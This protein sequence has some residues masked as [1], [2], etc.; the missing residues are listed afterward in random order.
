MTPRDHQLP[1]SLRPVAYVLWGIHL[2]TVA[3]ETARSDETLYPIVFYSEGMRS[4]PTSYLLV[5]VSI[6]LVIG[7][8]GLLSSL[9]DESLEEFTVIT[10]G[11]LSLGMLL[12]YL[13]SGNLTGSHTAGLTFAAFGLYLDYLVFSVASW[14]GW[15]SGLLLLF[16]YSSMR[17]ICSSRGGPCQKHTRGQAPAGR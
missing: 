5:T 14:I 15:G 10:A 2:A 17:I 4:T 7:G 13:C 16:L 6:C 1:D 11:I 9:R 12:A 8:L 3:A